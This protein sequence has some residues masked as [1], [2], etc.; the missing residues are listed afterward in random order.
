MHHAPEDDAMTQRGRSLGLGRRGILAGAAALLGAGLARLGATERAEASHTEF[1]AGTSVLHL[2]VINDGTSATDDDAHS[3]IASQTVLVGS[4]GSGTAVLKIVQLGVG[5]TRVGLRVVGATN[6]GGGTGSGGDAIAALGGNPAGAN[7]GGSG[8]R[9]VG[10]A[11]AGQSS[12]GGPGLHGTGGA[13]PAQGTG[14]VGVQG[15][16]GAAQASLAIPGI[17]VVGIGGDGAGSSSGGTGVKGQ[18]GGSSGNQGNGVFGSTDSVIGAGV[19]GTNS[20]AGAGVGGI[21]DSGPGVKGQSTSSFGVHGVSSS[22]FGVFGQSTSSAGLFGFSASSIGFQG[23]SQTN[24][25]VL[26]Y[27]P[28]L[29]GIEALSDSGTA[30]LAQST[31]GLAGQFNG[32]VRINGALV[33]TGGVSAAGAS[34]TASASTLPHADGTQRRTLSVQAP[35]QLLEDV[36]EGTL[37]QGKAIVKLDDD[38]AGLLRGARYQVFPV[39]EGDC[40]GL[41]VANKSASGF[42]VR[43]L[44]GGTSGVG[45]SYRILARLPRQGGTRLERVTPSTGAVQLP[46][47]GP[48]AVPPL[49]VPGVVNEGAKP[50]GGA[51]NGSE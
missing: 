5:T 45:F 30:L 13:A 26:G 18:G 44:K 50:R 22:S 20:G 15:T 24:V 46:D 42:E 36:G 3:A 47:G 8:V 31:S 7:A 37:S 38:F 33:V 40:N 10:G 12:D 23:T 43:E 27:S 35:D 17:G 16:G 28:G 51:T 34:A 4:T 21:G 32:N 48:K 6:T 29:I 2:G 11:S 49:P 25:G 39:A 14:G 9:A 1:T 41:Y 19:R